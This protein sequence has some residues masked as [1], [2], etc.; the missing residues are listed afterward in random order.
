MSD[1]GQEIFDR[2]PYE[3]AKLILEI[4]RSLEVEHLLI[5]SRRRT[6]RVA[7]ARQAAMTVLRG[8]GD[9][10]TLQ[11]VGDF[12]GRD[13]GTVI[14]AQK[15]MAE[16]MRAGDEELAATLA[17]AF[18][19]YAAARKEVEKSKD[20]GQETAELVK[21]GCRESLTEFQARKVAAA[22]EGR[23]SK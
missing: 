8:K 1:S 16:R 2:L 13:H 4:A 9:R 3:I 20:D 10:Y 18:R 11:D 7:L 6:M 22:N 14:H 5:M 21:A 12:F 15:V 19:V 17:S 23:G